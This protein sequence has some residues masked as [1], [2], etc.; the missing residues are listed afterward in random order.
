MYQRQLLVLFIF[1][2]VGLAPFRGMEYFSLQV[3]RHLKIP[4]TD[5]VN[6]LIQS[7]EKKK[8]GD[9]VE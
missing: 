7:N 2:H 3:L 9:M 6:K 8:V 5:N 1:I 4:K